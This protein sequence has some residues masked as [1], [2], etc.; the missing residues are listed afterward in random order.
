MK[1]SFVHVLIDLRQGN[2]VRDIARRGAPSWETFFPVDSVC[3]EECEQELGMALQLDCLQGYVGRCRLGPKL[4]RIQNLKNQRG[5]L[6]I[7][8]I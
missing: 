3:C 2:E 8:F 7:K 1:T 4:V 5:N 6:K